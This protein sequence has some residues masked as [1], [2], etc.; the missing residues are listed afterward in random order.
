MRKIGWF[1]IVI[2]LFFAC[3]NDR[4]LR[5]DIAAIPVELEIVRFDKI[6]AN[7]DVSDIPKL[8][9]Q[10]P[11]FFP[12]QYADSIWE[13]RISDSLQQQLNEEVL[14][15]F[16]S[17]EKFEESLVSLFQHIKYYLPG[18]SVPQVYITTSDV[19]YKT[20]VI[21]N[22]SMLV[23]EL[24]TYLGS[25]HPFYEGI[26]RY[27]TKNMKSDQIV[28]DVASV[29]AKKFIAVPRTRTFLAQMIYFGKELYLKDLWLSET[30]DYRK[31]GYTEDEMQWA[32]DN[33]AEIWRYFI[34]NEVLYSTDIKLPSRFISPA[35]FSKF[36]LDI[37]NESPGMIGRFI[38]WQIV[39]S[40]V[41]KNPEISLEQLLLKSP[42]E[43]FKNSN[44]KP[45][46]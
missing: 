9:N 14:K 5:S 39:R 15:V 10:F 31:M 12:V 46:K 45:K 32:Y 23:I 19:D 34:E 18:F 40:Y 8:K 22:D 4:K 11:Q 30:E 41:D 44:Y 13:Q 7:A 3:N 42:D 26:S 29:Y 43:I 37:D 2:G 24:D 33:E 27:I 6:F 38:G 35:P 16:P 17:E 20:R 28:S 36:N 25:E 21:A 1:I